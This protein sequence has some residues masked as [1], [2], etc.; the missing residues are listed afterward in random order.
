MELSFVML[1]AYTKSD[2]NIASP[3]TIILLRCERSVTRS[4]RPL[5]A[6]ENTRFFFYKNHN[7]LAEARC[8]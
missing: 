5:A 2:F 8:S 3:Q 6:K 7:I 1:F 4:E